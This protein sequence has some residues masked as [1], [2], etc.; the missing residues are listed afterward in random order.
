MKRFLLFGK[1]DQRIE[2]KYKR[3]AEGLADY[4]RNY[5]FEELRGETLDYFSITAQRVRTLIK[6]YKKGKLEQAFEQTSD[7][8][9]RDSSDVRKA[10]QEFF[11]K[12]K[13]KRFI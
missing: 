8:F 3:L 13:Y 7:L 9:I 11:E 4:V 6:A 5:P 2:K 1:T 12:K 10:I